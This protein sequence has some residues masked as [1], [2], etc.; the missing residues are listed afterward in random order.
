MSMEFMRP[1]DAAGTLAR[2]GP[3][4][5]ASFTTFLSR[6]ELLA[7]VPTCTACWWDLAQTAVPSPLGDGARLLRFL[8]DQQGCCYWYLLLLADGG[9]RVVCG[10]YRYD[11]YEVSADEAADDL[12]VVAPDFESFVYRFWVENLAWYEVAHAKRA[13]HDLSEPVRE[14]LAAYR[15]SGA[16]AP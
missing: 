7:A 11:R 14:Y 1:I 3:D 9:H 16:F 8:N 2:L 15:A 6:P 10:E 5:P 4:L 13:W 12:L